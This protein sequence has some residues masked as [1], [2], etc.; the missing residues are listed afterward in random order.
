MGGHQT[1]EQWRGGGHACRA[2]CRIVRRDPDTHSYLGGRWL[3]QRY[4][5]GSLYYGA[6]M[7]SGAPRLQY[8]PHH[9]CNTVC[10]AYERGSLCHYA[11][12]FP[13]QV[14][15]SDRGSPL[16]ASFVR[17]CVLDCVRTSCTGSGSYGDS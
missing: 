4:S 9:G 13:S 1:E 3:H 8:G 14:R 12:P 7:V 11:G 16:P 10:Q 15:K 5:R 6:G 17:G 2:E